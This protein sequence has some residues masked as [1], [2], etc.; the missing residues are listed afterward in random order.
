MCVRFRQWQIERVKR[1]E[2]PLR[3]NPLVLVSRMA[4]RQV[5]V[6]A[7]NFAAASGVRGG[8]T[9][10]EAK[11][12]C[13][14]LAHVDHDPG[15]DA[16][17]LQ[18]FAH[19][20]VR[21]SPVVA[22]AF[23]DALLLDMTGSERLYG[24]FEKLCRNVSESLK[25]LRFSCRI[26]IAATP[27]AAWA[28]ASYGRRDCTI[29][30]EKE[31]R[32]A[33][34][35]LPVAALRLEP[36]ILES[37]HALGIETVSQLM[38]LPRKNLPTRFGATLLARIDQALGVIAEP[39]V[40]VRFQGPIEAMLEFESPV[41]S[42]DM[43]W[44]ALRRLT[45]DVISQLR[46]RGRG[47]K[48]LRL[49]FTPLDAAPITKEIHLCEASANSSKL[50]NLLR[51]ASEAV[52]TETGFVALAL[53]V[54]VSERLTSE[55]LSLMDAESREAERDFSDLI[56][57]LTLRL[58]ENA[59]QTAELVPHHLPERAF[60][61]SRFDAACS[62][63]NKNP[64]TSRH[65]ARPIRLLP[66]PEEVNCMVYPLSD[67]A[68]F[69][70]TF[71]FHGKLHELTQ[72]RGPERIGGPWYDGRDKTRDYFDVEDQ[73]GQRFWLFRI[74]ETRKWYLHGCF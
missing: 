62:Q 61:F 65:K 40:P 6:H 9:L 53:R 71:T 68:G 33:L 1:K 64:A 29:T 2:K 43:L 37:L 15:K 32:T 66:Q 73:T 30:A 70:V 25:K 41:E 51:L 59:V 11:A 23:P 12:L 47:A 10:A 22:A 50:L 13:P 5:V 55:Q 14:G 20:M 28:I 3:R 24:G 74:A 39:L 27:G 60:R 7:C 31:I 42:L 49:E 57:R 18:A 63:Q 8:M 58:G 45:C 34:M 17:S 26:A 54:P 56:E 36:A 35:P 67:D 21:F 48:K 38:A 4:S 72:A 69:P 44:E 52:K 16:R 19:W 46:E